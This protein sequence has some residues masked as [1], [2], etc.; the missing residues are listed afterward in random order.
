MADH[1]ELIQQFSAISGADVD[2]AKHFLESSAWNLATALSSYFEPDQ[3]PPSANVPAAGA[4]AAADAGAAANAGAAEDA[5]VGGLAEDDSDDDMDDDNDD[6]ESEDE[7][8]FY[9]GGSRTSGQQVLG[10]KK[11]K[12]NIVSSLFKAAKEHGAEVVSDVPGTSKPK[13]AVFKGTSYRLGETEDDTQVIADPSS[14]A[15]SQEVPV[16]LRIYSQGFTVDDG[17]LRNFTD[18]Q[19]AQFLNDIKRGRIPMELIVRAKGRQVSINM[20]NKIH[21]DYEPKKSSLKAFTGSGNTLGSLAPS[22]SGQVTNAGPGGSANKPAE[23][24]DPKA[25][26]ETAKTQLNLNTS[27]PATNIQVRLGDGSRLVVRA[28]HTHTIADLRTYITTARP[29]YASQPFALMTTFPHAELADD[30]ASLKSA[31]ILNSAIVLKNK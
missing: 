5:G 21:E 16:D 6:D 24:A 7:Q 17:P 19:N 20:T 8:A 11:S 31:N 18:P 27:E 14:S 9:A 25:Q 1:D 2:R 23:T 4:G 10:P 29:Q 13:K 15:R 22:V 12:K 30:S 3:E 28:N 26:E